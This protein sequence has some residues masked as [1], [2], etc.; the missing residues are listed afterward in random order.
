M[1]MPY[2]LSAPLLLLGACALAHA[3][4]DT[5]FERT[6]AAQPR[7]VV[8]ISNVAGSIQVSGWDRSEV[9]VHADLGS[10]VERVDVTS[11]AGRTIIKVVLPS[12]SDRR[13]EADLTVKIP[14]DSEL[15]VSAV[16]SDIRVSG[17]LG[18]QR[19]NAVSGDVTAE[20]A[21]SDADVKTV[22]GDVRLKGHGQPLRLHASSVSGDVHVEHAA[23]DLEAS[24]VSGELVASLDSARS[25]RARSTSGE[26]TFEAKLTRGADVDVSSVSGEIK[27]RGAADGGYSY[28]VSSFSGDISDCFDVKPQRAG[29]YMPGSTLQGTRG[30]GAGHV[31]LKTMSGEVYLCDRN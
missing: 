8:D 15:D 2:H 16:S 14:K 11:E 7:G 13:G 12:H 30:D 3:S 1:R 29:Q 4:D 18:V 23:G 9:S 28:E 26:L 27:L 22:S 21:G 6:V 10:G 5:T 24:T 19:L 25:I 31:R 20:L 17:V